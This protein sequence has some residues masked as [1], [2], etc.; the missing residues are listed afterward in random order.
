MELA[1]LPLS[2]SDTIIAYFTCTWEELSVLVETDRHD[3][4][5][6]VESFFNTITVVDVDI[7][8]DYSLMVSADQPPSGCRSSYSPQ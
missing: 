1:S 8:I 7:D 4:I 2:F 3:S 6:R 5:S